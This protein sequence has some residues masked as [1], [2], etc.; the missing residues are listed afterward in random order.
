MKFPLILLRIWIFLFLRTVQ[1]CSVQVGGQD[2]DLSKLQT[3]GK[4]GVVDV[5]PPK[6]EQGLY[7]YE[8]SFCADLADCQNNFGNL[9]RLHD[10]N[11]YLCMGLYGK[12]S[13]AVN[14]K[15][16]NGYD[17]KFES[18]EYCAV[19]FKKRYSST[20]QFLCNED[21]GTLGTVEAKKDGDDTCSYTVSVYTDLVCSGSTP[22]PNPSPTSPTASP[23]HPA[24]TSSAGLSAGSIFLIAL[25]CAMF[26]YILVGIGFNY[27]KEQSYKTPH[28]NFWCSKLPYWTKMGC[29]TSWIW[30][31]WCSQ[32][33]YHWC[34][35]HV[36]K[37]NKGDDSMATGILEGEQNSS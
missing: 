19:D 16:T 30:T 4:S 22:V 10:S 28:Q 13:S 2:Y 32:S 11:L 21:V 9:A 15:T 5:T 18:T 31:L 29:I 34:C 17:A 24:G 7:K 23:A 12:W 1:C 35:S 8:A 20:F 6:S 37:R 27:R 3:A 25:L 14:T 26:M 36:C 33:S